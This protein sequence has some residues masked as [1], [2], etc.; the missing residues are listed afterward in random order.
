[1]VDEQDAMSKMSS[2]YALERS[3][4]DASKAEVLSAIEGEKNRI[5]VGVSE[6]TLQQVKAS[7]NARFVVGRLV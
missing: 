5:Q 2:E 3:K 7:I 4:L 6:G 1:M